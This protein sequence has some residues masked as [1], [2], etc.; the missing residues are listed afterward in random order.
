MSGAPRFRKERLVKVLEAFAA[1]GQ[2][3]MNLWR[4]FV[5]LQFWNLFATPVLLAR[6]AN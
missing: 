6:S 3:V 5:L 2:P 4:Y 1:A